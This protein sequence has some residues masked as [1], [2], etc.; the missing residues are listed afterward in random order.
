[1]PRTHI[2][3]GVVGQTFWVMLTNSSIGCRRA[4]G[5]TISI[6]LENLDFYE[7]VEEQGFADIVARNTGLT[8][9]PEDMFGTRRTTRMTTRW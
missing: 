7:I 9:L 8:D 2:N 6:G 1:M 4:T 5:F 3:G